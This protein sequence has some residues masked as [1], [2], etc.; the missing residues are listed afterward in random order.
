MVHFE[1]TPPPIEGGTIGPIAHSN[2]CDNL[3]RDSYAVPGKP[4]YDSG[5]Q[6]GPMPSNGGRLYE[7]PSG[8][9]P[10]CLPG[11]L[12]EVELIGHDRPMP[13][14]WIA[15]ALSGGGRDLMPKDFGPLAHIPI[16][17]DAIR[18]GLQL[19]KWFT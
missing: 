6:M 17:G 12:Q 11:G 15:P 9:G 10:H 2:V 13:G 14:K 4:I 18:S 19:R 7:L 16:V 3:Y 5:W 1:D 8:G